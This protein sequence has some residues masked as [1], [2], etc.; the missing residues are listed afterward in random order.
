MR[1][2]LYRGVSLIRDRLHLA[3]CVSEFGLLRG[4]PKPHTLTS[5]CR[6]ATPSMKQYSSCTCPAILSVKYAEIV[7]NQ[8]PCMKLV[9][10][11]EGTIILVHIICR[12]P[13]SGA[14]LH[15][16]LDCVCTFQKLLLF[17]RLRN[18]GGTETRND[19]TFD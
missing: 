6:P 1:H 17:A 10:S 15:P 14:R 4:A 12:R 16:L 8:M 9:A 3:M 18:R 19:F 7:A 5:G 13:L 2:H 11:D